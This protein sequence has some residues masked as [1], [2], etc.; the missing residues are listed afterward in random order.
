[1]SLPAAVS[2]SFFVSAPNASGQWLLPTIPL[3][4][5][6]F[7]GRENLVFPYVSSVQSSPPVPALPGLLGVVYCCLGQGFPWCSAAISPKEIPLGTVYGS[8]CV[9]TQN[10][11]VPTKQPLA[12][13]THSWEVQ[14]SC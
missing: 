12:K 5:N 9:Q 14:N 7:L 10:Q 11:G 4:F 13:E 8:H 2:A 6:F 3:S 1:M